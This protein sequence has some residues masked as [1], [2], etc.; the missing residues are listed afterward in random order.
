MPPTRLSELEYAI[1][2]T[3]HCYGP[4]TAYRVRRAFQ[5]SLS[6][7]WTGSAGAV[8][9]AMAR[10][11]QAGLVRSRRETRGTRYRALLQLAGEGRRKLVE[12]LQPPLPGPAAL[13]GFDPLRLRVR[14][15]SVLA[16]EQR[17]AFLAAADRSLRAHLERIRAAADE[18]CRAGDPWRA[19]VH[20]GALLSVRAQLDWIAELRK[21]H[22]EQANAGD[23]GMR[24]DR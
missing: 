3:I 20:R 11:E 13:M 15:L 6:A 8:Y 10:L 24:L 18:T 1:L 19:A 7:H 9:P 4:C 12:W 23:A 16:R 2:G 22:A 17:R 21:A 14:F 5:T